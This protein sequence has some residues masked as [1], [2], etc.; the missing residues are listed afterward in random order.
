MRTEIVG[1]NIELTQAIREFATQKSS[2]LLKYFDGIQQITVTLT[3][4]DHHKHGL[5][6][7]ELIVDVEKHDNFVSHEHDKDL[8]VAIDAAVAKS[9]RQL[10]DFKEKLK[11]GK[12]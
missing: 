11:L 3:K 2:K 1:R 8:Y 4:D 12:H 9:E 6:G 7:A 5:F 10:R